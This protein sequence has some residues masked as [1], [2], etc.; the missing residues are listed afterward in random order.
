MLH[1]LTKGDSN[2]TLKRAAEDWKGWRYGGMMLETCH[3]AEDCILQN[4][5]LTEQNRPQSHS[6][7]TD[8]L[9]PL[10]YRLLKVIAR[11]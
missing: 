1:H 3:T 7:F 4:N 6:V 5:N 9:T 8:H 2:A 10:A 11:G